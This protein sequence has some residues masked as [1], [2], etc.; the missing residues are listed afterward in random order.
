MISLIAYSKFHYQKMCVMWRLFSLAC[1]MLMLIHTPP[2][3]PINQKI[4]FSLLKPLL[5]S[6]KESF[7]YIFVC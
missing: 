4:K 1:D 2:D 7:N 5:K 3:L 6:L